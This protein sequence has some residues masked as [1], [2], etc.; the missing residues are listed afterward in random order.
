MFAL[1]LSP[2]LFQNSTGQS[3]QSCLTHSFSTLTFSKAANISLYLQPSPLPENPPKNSSGLVRL[4]HTLSLSLFISF[5]LFHF[6]FPHFLSRVDIVQFQVKKHGFS[7]LWVQENNS[8]LTSHHLII[9]TIVVHLRVA[10][11]VY[12]V[13]EK[14][15][16]DVFPFHFFH[17]AVY[18]QLTDPREQHSGVFVSHIFHHWPIP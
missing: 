17:N 18:G 13:L 15:P 5:F 7:P 4:L 6:I 10:P 9:W 14:K 12:L 3:G 11:F 8:V 1:S 2:F 16:G